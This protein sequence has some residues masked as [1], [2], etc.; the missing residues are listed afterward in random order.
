MP[1]KINREMMGDIKIKCD[2]TINFNVNVDGEPNPK[3]QWF[4]NGTPLT[5][6]DRTRIDN[7]TENNTKLVTRLAERIDSGR[8]KL[9]STNENGTD[10]YEVE[11][12]VLGN[13]KSNSYS[14]F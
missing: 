8:Y 9:V 4:I 6:S 1:P 13:V 7:T 10:E 2:S 11:V 3:N 12:V 14:I 5:T